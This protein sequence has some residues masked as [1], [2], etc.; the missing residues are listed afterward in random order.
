MLNVYIDLN[1]FS[2]SSLCVNQHDVYARGLIELSKVNKSDLIF[3]FR[4][5]SEL[6]TDS[7]W[8]KFVQKETLIKILFVQSKAIMISDILDVS[9]ICQICRMNSGKRP[10]KNEK[11]DFLCLVSRKL[12]Q[13]WYHFKCFLKL[14]NLSY[15]DS[16]YVRWVQKF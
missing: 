3:D 5:R 7:W 12:V 4:I 1:H 8:F 14:Y 11:W 6:R 9:I 16:S 10:R 15:S 13:V 2:K